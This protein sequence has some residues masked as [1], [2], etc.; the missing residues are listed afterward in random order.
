MSLGDGV[1]PNS[2]CKRR[3]WSS[4]EAAEIDLECFG[5]FERKSTQPP[6][7]THAPALGTTTGR[8]WCGA[9]PSSCKGPMIDD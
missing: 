4:S 7:G 3:S 5:C 8:E 9:Q 2:K 6:E 1:P